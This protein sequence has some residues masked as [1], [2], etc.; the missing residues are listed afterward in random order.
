MKTLTFDRYTS[1]LAHFDTSKVA[2]AVL[3]GPGLNLENLL[4]SLGFLEKNLS[5]TTQG[6]TR[7]I[8]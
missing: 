4:H 1:I 5:S 3:F 8:R 2:E 7:I 6:T